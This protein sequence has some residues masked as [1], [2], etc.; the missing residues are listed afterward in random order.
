MKEVLTKGFWQGVK[1]T[2]SEALEG[3]AAEAKASQADATGNSEAPSTSDAPSS[4]ATSEQ[5]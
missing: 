3:S 1:K 5:K 2:F 4:S